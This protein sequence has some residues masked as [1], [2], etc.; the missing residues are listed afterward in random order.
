[1]GNKIYPS[2]NG[3]PWLYCAKCGAAMKWSKTADGYDRTTG[4]FGPNFSWRCPNWRPGDASK[5]HDIANR[6]VRD[7]THFVLSQD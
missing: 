3:E 6:T 2:R 4:E 1:M 5:S 7:I